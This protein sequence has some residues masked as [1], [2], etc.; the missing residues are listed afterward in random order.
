MG[1]FLVAVTV[2][3]FVSLYPISAN[4]AP[5]KWSRFHNSFFIALSRPAFL[6]ALM[7]IMTVLML[8]HV[9]WLNKFLKM[10]V[11]LPL[12][13]LSFMVYLIFP[14]V[15][16]TL[17]SSMVISLQ[18]SYPTMFYLLSF[19]LVVNFNM[20]FVLYIFIE[21]PLQRIFL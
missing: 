2:I 14:T 21:A 19:N 15:N 12:S 13:R 16:A 5:M 7:L 4:K 20:A 17:L 3:G 1:S 10:G 8:G 6:L 9:Q 18:L 11:W